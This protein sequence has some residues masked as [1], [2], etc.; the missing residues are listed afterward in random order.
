M[1]EGHSIHRLA[2]RHDRLLVGHRVAASSPQGRFAE[3]AALLDGRVLAQTHARGKHLF[4]RYVDPAAWPQDRDAPAGPDDRWLHVHLGLYGKWA[5]GRGEPEPPRGALRLRLVSD[6]HWFDL[7]G[8]TACE[9]LTPGGRQ[10]ILDRLGP[11]PLDPACDPAP[12]TRRI[13]RSRAPIGTLLMDQSVVAGI[14]NVYRAEVLLRSRVSPF[15]PGRDLDATT[16]SHLWEDLKVL[17]EAGVRA[18]RIVTTEPDHRER[19]AGRPR[20]VDATYVY[21]RTGL[22]CRICDTPV[23]AAELGARRVFWCPTCQP[24]P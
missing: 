19:P 7:R 21:G 2:R 1:P 13:G 3:G 17:M 22:P 6:A 16:W 18:G 20:R 12:A 4:H 15:L 24:D 9:L 10:A 23:E 5:D 14:G 11:D 8:P